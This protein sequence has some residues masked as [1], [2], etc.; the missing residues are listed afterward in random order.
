MR[1]LK[2]LCRFISVLVFLFSF[3]KTA[4]AYEGEMSFGGF[5]FN[6][7]AGITKDNELKPVIDF[8]IMPLFIE[9]DSLGGGEGGGSVDAGLTIGVSGIYG[10]NSLPLFSS[11][12]DKSGDPA[13]C[14]LLEAGYAERS[15]SGWPLACLSGSFYGV[16][17]A[18]RVAHDGSPAGYGV[19]IRTSWHLMLVMIGFR[20]IWIMGPEPEG[21]FYVSAGFGFF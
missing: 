17:A 20:A 13:A 11:G 10:I 3:I 7:A 2:K 15:Q 12:R 14:W 5:H 4:S 6:Y 16:G 19:G 21:R 1:N 18:Y 8:G 9:T